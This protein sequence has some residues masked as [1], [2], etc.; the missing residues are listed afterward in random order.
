MYS[1]SVVRVAKSVRQR[2][3]TSYSIVITVLLM[4]IV[5]GLVL[6]GRCPLGGTVPV[7][8]LVSFTIE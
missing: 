2:S 5:L 3:S 6:K 4:Y 8:E 7:D 1:Q